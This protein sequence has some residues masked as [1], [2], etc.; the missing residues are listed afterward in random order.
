MVRRRLGETLA[1]RIVDND[2]FPVRDRLYRMERI[3]WNDS[4]KAR[5][6]ALGDARD[7]QFELAFQDFVDLFL[8]V[9]ML[10]D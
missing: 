4:D 2:E 1:Q 8:G 9:G 7:R 3:R 10:M 6:Q 5:P